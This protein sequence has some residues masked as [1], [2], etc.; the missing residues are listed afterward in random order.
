MKKIVL[1]NDILLSEVAR[2]VAEGESVTIRT[3]GN[4]ML[5]FIRGERD[6]VVLE[7]PDEFGVMDIVLAEIRQGMFVL[8]R[9]VDMN[10]DEVVLM[11]DGNLVGRERCL[12][13]D[14]AAKAVAIVKDGKKVDCRSRGH[15]CR[16]RIWKSL[17]PLRRYLLAIYRRTRE[18]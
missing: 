15:L 17:L 9:V 8:H 11:G 16:A 13:N 6:S 12:R 10:G 4:S 5:P 18:L 3:K 2:L 1:P 7:A 14:V